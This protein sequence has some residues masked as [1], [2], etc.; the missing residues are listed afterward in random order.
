MP[1]P[2]GAYAPL[3]PLTRRYSVLEEKYRTLRMYGYPVSDEEADMVDHMRARWEELSLKAKIRD[4]SLGLVKKEFTLVTQA[5]VTEFQK[6]VVEL[7]EVYNGK[8]GPDAGGIDLDEGLARMEK[9]TVELGA[10]VR[11]RE[12][13]GLAQKLFNLPIQPYPEL[14]EMEASL[15]DLKTIFDLYV[16]QKEARDVWA[17][18]LWSEL[19]M[20]TM[21]KGMEGFKEALGKLDKRLKAYKPYRLAEESINAFTMSLP[22]IQNLKGE[23]LRERH[24]KKL[25][26][27]TGVT[28]DMNPR[29]FTLGSLFEMNLSSFEEAIMEICSGA[30]KELNIENGISAIADTW[31]VQRFEVVKYMKGTQ[32]RG[33]VLRSTDEIQQTLEDQTMNLS[34]MM[35]SR[36]VAPFLELTQKWEK[37]MS[38]ISEVIEVWMKVQSKWMY[39]EAIF[40]GSEDIRLQLPEEAKRFDRIH[41]AFKKV[42]GETFKNPNVLDACTAEGRLATLQGLYAQLEACQKSLSDYLETKRTTFPRFYFLSDDELLQ[43]LGTSDPLAVQEHMLKLFDNTAALTFDRGGAKVL[44]MVSSEKETFAFRTP[45]PTEGAVEAWLGLVESEMITTLRRTQKECTYHYPQCD[46]LEWVKTNLGLMVNTGAQIWWTYEAADV[47]DKVRRGDKMGMKRFSAKCHEQLDNLIV[48]VRDT[49]G[50]KFATKKI[51][52]L[53]ILDVHARDII[54]MF[55]RDSVLDERDFAWES[56]LRFSWDRD[57]DDVLIRQCSGE[58]QFGYEYQGLAARLVITPLTDRCYMTC[59]QALHYR[60]GCAPAGPAGT[61]KTETVKDLSKAMALQC[62]VFCCGEGLDYKAMGSIFSGLV[63]T[64]AWGCFDEFNRIPVEVLSVVSAQIKTVQSALIDGLKRFTFEG[65][66]I[67]LVNTIG[68]FITMNPGYAGR[69][70]LPDNLKALFRPVVM[71]TPDLLLICENML[72]S[73]G[74]SKAKVLAKKMTVLYKLGKEQLSKQYHYDFGLRALKSVLVMAGGLKR[75]SP[76]FDEST[77]LMRALRDMNMPKFIFAD[78]PLFRG[79]IGDLF[80]GLDCPRVRYPSFNDAVEAALNEQG[81]QVLASPCRCLC[82]SL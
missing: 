70:E 76:E 59:T 5:Q 16:E 75:E 43:I 78:V 50:D 79:L 19:E 28:F 18:G 15:R 57:V 13:L 48:G 7:H 80:P 62:K 69:A 64:G 56:Q 41:N 34:S 37:L 71:V 11:T 60:L 58:F 12:Q 45:Q 32:E 8:G 17:S 54:D 30:I 73:E 3:P 81:F 9:F 66:E 40:V 65:R 53:I 26:E 49:K 31:R 74:F 22:L 21:E 38:T 61:G 47:F 68:I 55:V 77:I 6:E 24:W 44:G 67:A 1:L 29:T 46:R 42:M 51:N 72:M 39:L 25:M 82:A 20:S 35:S 4:H 27:V 52:T 14:S 2:L 23:A 36:F 63:Q 10:K 33:L